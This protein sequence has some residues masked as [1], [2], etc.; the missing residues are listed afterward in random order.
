[1]TGLCQL[2]FVILIVNSCPIYCGSEF[3]IEK[4][5]VNFGDLI[6]ANGTATLEFAKE[7]MNHLKVYSEEKIQKWYDF[8]KN[9]FY[10]E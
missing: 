6:T 4:Q 10:E 2:S 5:C 7:I 9:G 3:Y 8:N 1:M